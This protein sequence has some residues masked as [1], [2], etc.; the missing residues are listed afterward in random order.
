M[1]VFS[2]NHSVAL[3]EHRVR[4]K[5]RAGYV[6]PATPHDYKRLTRKP[7]LF[8][9]SR[10]GVFP[11]EHHGKSDPARHLASAYFP[12]CKTFVLCQPLRGG[13]PRISSRSLDAPCSIRS[14]GQPAP[15]GTF[16]LE[17]A[18]SDDMEHPDHPPNDEQ[19]EIE[20]KCMKKACK[21]RYKGV[22]RFGIIMHIIIK[23][24]DMHKAYNFKQ[25][26]HISLNCN[27]I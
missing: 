18:A 8:T 14:G 26:I 4:Q 12:P 10:S 15:P 9:H 13:A 2:G 22:E 23:I 20:V 19:R 7:N 24:C 5:K 27:N 16:P 1:I 17:P 21:R 3:L 11:C 25:K 6:Y